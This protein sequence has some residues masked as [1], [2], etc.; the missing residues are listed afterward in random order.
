MYIFLHFYCY[1]M[2][3]AM[4]Q[5]NDYDDDDDDALIVVR[6]Q[7]AT[8]WTIYHAHLFPFTHV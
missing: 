1:G 7:P 3:S 6:A 8:I 2:R 4:L 5:I